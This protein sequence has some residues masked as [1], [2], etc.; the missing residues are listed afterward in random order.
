MKFVVKWII[1]GEMSVEAQTSE[2]A[3]VIV[4]QRLVAC[5]T[6]AEKWPAEL[7]AKGIQGAASPEA[8]N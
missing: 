1:D 8:S 2:E 4:Q 7:G 3:E 5:L 6:D